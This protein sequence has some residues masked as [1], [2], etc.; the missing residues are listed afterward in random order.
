LTGIAPP[1]YVLLLQ[2][3][4]EGGDRAARTLAST[5]GLSAFYVPVRGDA[6]RSSGNAILSSRPLENP[7]A[8]MLVR[9]RQPR[10]AALAA[11]TVAGER[12]FIVNVHMENRVVWWRGLF[13]D[14]ARGRQAAALLQALPQDEHG[15]LGGDLNTWLGPTERAWR[16]IARRFP[17]TP[18]DRP[19]PTFHDRLV[20]DHLFFDLP[21]GWTITRR[22][23]ENSYDSDHHPVVA[24]VT[25]QSPPGG[26]A[27]RNPPYVP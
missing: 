12:L 25:A 27:S 6:G 1:D 15:V 22:V 23:L 21:E 8:V 18:D 4:I 5:R 24:V 20:L 17:D 3:D 16:V 14:L 13:S 10:A 9:E 2:E 11:V 7:R 26:S 19:Q